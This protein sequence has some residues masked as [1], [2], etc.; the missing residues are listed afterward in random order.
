M[1]TTRVQLSKKLLLQGEALA[2]HLRK[3]VKDTGGDPKVCAWCDKEV[4][5]GEYVE[6][7][8][9]KNICCHECYEKNWRED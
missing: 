7:V 4:I 6:T 5:E 8:T 1:T 9:E 2:E 3:C